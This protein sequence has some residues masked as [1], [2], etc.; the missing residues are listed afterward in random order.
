MALG[1]LPLLVLVLPPLEDEV[2]DEDELLELLLEL[3][4]ED[5]VAPE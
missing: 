2:E 1:P 4:E 3:E 5:V